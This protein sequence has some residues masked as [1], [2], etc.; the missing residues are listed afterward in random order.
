MGNVEFKRPRAPRATWS[1]TVGAAIGL[2]IASCG[3]SQTPRAPM[4]QATALKPAP[5][6][7]V[8]YQGLTSQHAKIGF[9][10]DRG[11]SAIT[12]LRFSV[13]YACPRHRLLRLHA[14][15][16]RPDDAW[17]L[18]ERWPTT[19]IG[20]SDWF[21]GP[22]GHD[23]HVTGTLSRDASVLS[24]TIHSLLR[25]AG[26]RTG[27]DSGHLRFQAALTASRLGLPVAVKLTLHQY[28][29]LP[30][31]ITIASARRILGPPN[32]RDIFSPTRVVADTA[33]YGPP[34]SRQSWLDYRWKGHPRRYFQF[35]FHAGRLLSHALGRSIVDT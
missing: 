11:R 13:G 6:A 27:C 24:G 15:I 9:V 1:C 32:D 4:R 35:S 33:T 18:V 12:A 26:R 8:V 21:S 22:D 29:A 25:A 14:L 5:V 10:V 19:V 23:F 7:V 31:G 28:K 3:A 17:R 34:G 16:L 2:L 20:F 30:S